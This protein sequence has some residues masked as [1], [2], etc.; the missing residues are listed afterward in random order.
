MTVP[1][2]STPHVPLAINPYANL[3]DEDPELEEPG[4]CN[5]MRLIICLF[6]LKWCLAT[7]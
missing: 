6:L 7:E 4:K 5:Y 3:M 2:I 1:D